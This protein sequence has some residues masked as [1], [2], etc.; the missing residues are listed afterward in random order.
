M[1]RHLREHQQNMDCYYNDGR[2]AALAWE[3]PSYPYFDKYGMWAYKA[4]FA[5]GIRERD[6]IEVRRRAALGCPCPVF[7]PPTIGSPE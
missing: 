5:D 6:R 7:P 4:G 1:N 3:D 2:R